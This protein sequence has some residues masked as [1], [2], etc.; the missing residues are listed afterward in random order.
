[1]GSRLARGMQRLLSRLAMTINA[2]AMRHGKLWRD[3]YHRRD[4]TTP[5]QY[6]ER[7]SSTSSSTSGS[8]R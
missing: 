5:Q 8:T 4:L 1:M 6:P 3:R 2:I 7:R